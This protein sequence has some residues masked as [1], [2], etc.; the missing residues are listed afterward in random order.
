MSVC[1][2]NHGGVIYTPGITRLMSGSGKTDTSEDPSSYL[3]DISSSIRIFLLLLLV[4]RFPLADDDDDE[5]T[6]TS[7]SATAEIVP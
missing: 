5:G 1:R 4:C 3:M 2:G 6:S 7:F